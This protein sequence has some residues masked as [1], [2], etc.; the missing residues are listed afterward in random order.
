M[1]RIKVITFIF[2]FIFLAT[3]Y[4]KNNLTSASL[5][6]EAWAAHQQQDWRAAIKIADKCINLFEEEAIIQQTSL[7]ELPSA[8][9]A[10]DYWALNDVGACYYIKCEALEKLGD[11]KQ[12]ELIMSLNKLAHELSYAQ[13]WDDKGWYWQPASTSKKKLR[14]IE[15]EAMLK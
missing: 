7:T 6:D 15:F 12:E 9:K 11:K 4:G 1:K 13:C 5:T 10:P 14:K 2:T 8:E 3:S